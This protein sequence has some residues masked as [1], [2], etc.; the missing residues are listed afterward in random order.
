M[1]RELSQPDFDVVIVGGGA[2][3]V[4]AAA[5]LALACPNGKIGL[6]EKDAVLGGRLRGTDRS[7]QIFGYGLNAASDTLY[8]FWR[9]TILGDGYQGEIEADRLGD[10]RQQRVGVLA[11]SKISEVPIDQWFTSKGARMLGGLVAAR[12]WPEV[13][14]LFQSGTVAE[15]HLPAK[16]AR[17]GA[18]AAAL[19][20]E[21]MKDSEWVGDEEAAGA[22]L[23]H[24]VSQ[25]WKRTRKAASAEVLEHFACA[26]GIPDVW[27]A[28]A[29]AVAERARYYGG[30]LYAGIWDDAIRQLIE[31][32]WFKARVT[33]LVGTRVVEAEPT[34]DRWT[35]STDAGPIT[36]RALIV[37]QPPWQAMAWLKRSLWPAQLL[38]VASKTKLV[39]VV[40]L[41]E[42]VEQPDLDIPDILIVPS[43]HAQ[44]IRNGPREITFQ[45]TIDFELSMQAPAVVKAVRSLKRARK[46]LLAL[47]PGSISETNQIAL[48]PVAWAQPPAHSE[49]RW[50]LRAAKKPANAASLA[51]C[52]DAYGGSYDG[53]TN[54]VKSLLAACAAVAEVLPVSVRA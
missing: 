31:R 27:S 14:Q 38:H 44:I 10:R 6:I 52:G 29:E 45:A 19:A 13:E 23:D 1:D 30:R 50:L 16:P 48:I 37:A 4:L 39:S 49:R 25:L 7:A 3:G 9:Q 53:D 36:G 28:S 41:S 42:L 32:P 34:P 22:T 54:V 40:V 20:D 2:A 35:L 33:V 46:K 24:P 8:Q 11:G 12:E 26:F 51:F 15:A 47:Y 17:K 21:A 43:E 18:Q 5:R